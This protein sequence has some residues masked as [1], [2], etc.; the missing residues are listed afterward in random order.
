MLG[1]AWLYLLPAVVGRVV[2]ARH[3]GGHAW[4]TRPVSVGVLLSLLGRALWGSG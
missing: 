3:T 1:L 4:L 2:D